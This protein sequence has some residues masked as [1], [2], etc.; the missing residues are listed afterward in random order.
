MEGVNEKLINRTRAL[1]VLEKLD[2]LEDILGVT[3]N[4]STTS[5]KIRAMQEEI[6]TDA[7]RTLQIEQIKNRHA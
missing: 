4:T 3:F 1:L 7:D 2:A 6:I 5:A